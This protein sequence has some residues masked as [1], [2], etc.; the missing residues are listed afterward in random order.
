MNIGKA[1]NKNK[2]AEVAAAFERF[3]IDNNITIIEELD[4][5]LSFPD[6][7]LPFLVHFASS[8]WGSGTAL[9]RCVE[10][11]LWVVELGQ[12]FWRPT[13]SQ[14]AQSWSPGWELSAVEFPSSSL[15]LSFRLY[16]P[17]SEPPA[18]TPTVN[19]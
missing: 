16:W 1:Y 6:S 3:R 4:D 2:L 19:A 13:L 15:E 9:P 7:L 14:H 10:L 17:A 11:L 5:F 8:V 18:L 12:R